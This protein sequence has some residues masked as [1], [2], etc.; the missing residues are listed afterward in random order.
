[1]SITIMKADCGN[2][3]TNLSLRRF[4]CVGPTA[5]HAGVL[6]CT[7]SVDMFLEKLMCSDVC[8]EGLGD[9][10][11]CR[12][13]IIEKEESAE[14]KKISNVLH[15]YRPI[16]RKLMLKNY[17]NRN[18]L[19]RESYPDDTS[20]D[21]ET[22]SESEFT[23]NVG[24]EE[25][26]QASQE[27][28]IAFMNTSYGKDVIPQVVALACGHLYHLSCLE[29][30]RDNYLWKL[31]N[32]QNAFMC[33]VC[34][35]AVCLYHYYAFDMFFLRSLDNSLKKRFALQETERQRIIEETRNEL[36]LELESAKE[37]AVV[38][39]DSGGNSITPKRKHEYASP[40]SLLK[41]VFSIHPR[42]NGRARADAAI[43]LDL[44]RSTSPFGNRPIIP[45]NHLRVEEHSFLTP[46]T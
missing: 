15:T 46:N 18:G 31:T 20:E 35:K 38:E 24:M 4:T 40:P 12:M 36:L 16:N 19:P 11:I 7:T 26:N 30:S 39:V 2:V 21:S 29:R 32:E 6:C 34:K 45:F 33:H 10:V 23:G 9:C 22:E 14:Q 42:Y 25:E 17:R 37:S 43:P 1:M 13:E 27:E 8:A 28:D 5:A 44:T 3:A 41:R